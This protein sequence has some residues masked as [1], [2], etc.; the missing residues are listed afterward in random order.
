MFA[1]PTPVHARTRVPYRLLFGALEGLEMA[2]DMLDSEVPGERRFR[3]CCF[4]SIHVVA[5]PL[6]GGYTTDY[7]E[8][9]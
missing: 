6:G 4:Y 8:E 9:L 1:T 5:G 2:G 3:T 7:G